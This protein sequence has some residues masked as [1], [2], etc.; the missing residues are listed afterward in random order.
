MANN[1]G[2]VKLGERNPLDL[3]DACFDVL[4]GKDVKVLKP[5]IRGFTGTFDVAP[6]NHKSWLIRGKYD[7]KNMSTVEI[8]EV[9]PG[10]TYEK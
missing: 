2:A 7:I 10:F 5:W 3:I 1:I 9:P 4:D 8:T 6:D